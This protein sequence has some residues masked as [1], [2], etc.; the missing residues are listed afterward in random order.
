[1]EIIATLLANLQTPMFLA[2]FLGIIATIINSDLK[3]PDGMYTGLTIYLL[4]AIGLK[5]GVKLSNTSI[6]E[7]Y[8]PATAALYL[9]ISIPIIA[10]FLLT[11]LGKFDSINAAALAAHYGSVSA[12]TFSEALAFMDAQHITYEGFMPSML[13]IMEIPA[14]IIALYMVKSKTGDETGSMKK[15]LHELF[16]GKG[17][18]LLIG[19]LM[20]GMISGKKGLEQFGPL[21]DTPF[22]GVLVLFL[23]EVGIVTGRRLVD[24]KK[25]GL[26]LI[27]FAIL[28]PIFNAMIGLLLGKLAGLS[29]GGST[30]LATLSASA[31]YIAAPSA[32]R[33]ALPEA[34]P[35]YYLTASLAITFPFNISFGLPLY[36]TLAKFIYGV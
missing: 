32:I 16:A 19:G 30:I 10:Y 1:M 12:V 23:L 25:A 22:R 20:I 13:A 18:L 11:K 2:F 9:C 5:G 29:L 15:V 8:R 35:G 6:E 4:L 14:I 34:S 24:L 28:F 17:T 36:L 3:F 27:V 31:S 7:F 21:F 33:I 26:F